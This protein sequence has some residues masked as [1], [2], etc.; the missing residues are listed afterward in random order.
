M[1]AVMNDRTAMLRMTRCHQEIFND[2]QMTSLGL[3]PIYR[4]DTTQ[5]SFEISYSE[6]RVLTYCAELDDE[7]ES[8]K[9]LVLQI[10][11]QIR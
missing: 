3:T 2:F 1:S 10:D 5:V 7:E 8:G 9:P 6:W 11:E 4:G